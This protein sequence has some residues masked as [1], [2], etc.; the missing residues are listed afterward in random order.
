MT[1]ESDPDEKAAELRGARAD[2]A[3]RLLCELGDHVRTLVTEARGMNMSAIVADL[4]DT[5]Y[6]I[7][8]SRTT[9]WWHGSRSTGPKSHSF[10]RASMNR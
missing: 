2:D 5:I 4:A 7:D 8:R 9:P 1:N 3:R 6:A 10:L